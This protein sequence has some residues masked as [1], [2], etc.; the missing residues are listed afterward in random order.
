MNPYILWLLGLL[1]IFLEFYLPGA[2]LGIA[3]GILLFSSLVV[4]AGQST[5]FLSIALYF[6]ALCLSVAGLIPFTLR[7]IKKAKPE[8][9]IYSEASQDGFSASSYDRSAIGK[10][11]IVL[12]DLKPGGY[13]LLE[14]NQVQAISISG[15][16]PKGTEVIVIGGQEESLIVKQLKK[17]SLT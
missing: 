8:R 6:L 3:G 13:L 2:V 14:G 12:T 11:A 15:Y 1:L 10:T 4:F 9:S 7:R 16:L 17:D 5:S